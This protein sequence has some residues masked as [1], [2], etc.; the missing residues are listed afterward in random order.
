VRSGIFFVTKRLIKNSKAKIYPNVYVK[1]ET[2]MTKLKFTLLVLLFAVTSHS[3]SKFESIKDSDTIF[4]CFKNKPYE[5][6]ISLS[7]I[8]NIDDFQKNNT[9]YHLN[10]DAN[11]VISFHYDEFKSFEDYL[12]KTKSVVKKVDRKFLIKNKWRTIDGE[13]FKEFGY[14]KVFNAIQNKKIFLIDMS[15]NKRKLTVRQVRILGLKYTEE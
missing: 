9:V 6:K 13:F 7:A 15:K 3:Q 8:K 14:L 4:Y 11:N 12:T 2:T 1:Y 10:F 5:K